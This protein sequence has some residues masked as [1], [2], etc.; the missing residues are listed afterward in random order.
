MQR[1][2]LL[3]TIAIKSKQNSLSEFSQQA[4]DLANSLLANK[5]S[6]RLMDLY[7][8][9][10][11]ASK[12]TTSFNS[13]VVCDIERNIVKGKGTAIKR[14]T[15]KF[16]V[17]RRRVPVNGLLRQNGEIVSNDAVHLEPSPIESPRF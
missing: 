3:Q 16:N 14:I 17:P 15:V 8:A 5:K 9:T 4:V 6:K 13:Q 10:Y 12:K 1:V 7:R 11:L 2:I